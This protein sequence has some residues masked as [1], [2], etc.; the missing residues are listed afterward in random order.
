[1]IDDSDS[2]SKDGDRDPSPSGGMGSEGNPCMEAGAS[3]GTKELFP[4]ARVSDE[5]GDE[6]VSYSSALVE[7]SSVVDKRPAFVVKDGAAEV[8]IPAEIFEDV[9]PLW[10]S[11]VARYFINGARIL[12][13]FMLK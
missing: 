10:R 6:R 12:V 9:E 13:L 1:M 5:I 4:P 8:A 7:G 11:F 2:S 3:Q